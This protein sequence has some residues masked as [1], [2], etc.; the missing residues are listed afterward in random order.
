MKKQSVTPP[1][2]FFLNNPFTAKSLN[3][4][5]WC[6]MLKSPDK[7]EEEVEMNE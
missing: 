5:R 1:V 7:A 6:H 4:D 3:L 2:F